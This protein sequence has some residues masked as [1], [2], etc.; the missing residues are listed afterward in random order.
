MSPESPPLSKVRRSTPVGEIMNKQVISLQLAS[1]VSLADELMK[2][3][4]I[5]HLPV[6]EGKVLRGIVS[7]TDLY[8]NMLSYFLIDSEREQREFLDR[9]L[10]L[11]TLMTVE[12]LT[13]EP[14][15]TVGEALELMTQYRVSSI[16]VVNGQNELLGIVTDFDMLRLL[17]E[18]LK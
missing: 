18:T 8:K 9:V 11:H 7:Q 15:R 2:L 5:H 16:P 10:D 17:R 4:A 6:L 1:P 14:E 3:H 12:P 13:L